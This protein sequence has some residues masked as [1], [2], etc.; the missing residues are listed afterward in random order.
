M[1]LRFCCYSDSLG[2][3]SMSEGVPNTSNVIKIGFLFDH[4]SAR[5]IRLSK[6][7]F[8]FFLCAQ[9]LISFIHY[10]SLQPDEHLS[11]YLDTF[12]IVLIDDQTM[13]IP[14]KILSL[15]TTS[16]DN[17]M[18]QTKSRNPH[19][20]TRHLIGWKHTNDMK[21]VFHST[22]WYW[23][24]FAPF[25]S[26]IILS[27]SLSLSLFVFLFIYIWLFRRNITHCNIIFP[28]GRLHEYFS[29][30]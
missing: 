25:H 18:E 3:A 23:Y 20:I 16:V 12:D 2:D 10:F 27:L 29:L 6:I 13:D 8:I 26:F 4:V 28:P 14:R 21:F 11:K 9:I 24:S 15:I 7:T 19:R 30:N 22:C 1:I 5:Q 17:W